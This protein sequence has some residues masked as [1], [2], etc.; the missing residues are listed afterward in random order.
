M[1]VLLDSNVLIA[2]FDS[3]HV[4]HEPSTQL[5]ECCKDGDLLIAAHSLSE[6]YN[7]LTGG[8]IGPPFAPET[9]SFILNA[10]ARRVTVGSL[11]ADLTMDAIRTFARQNG[12]GPKLYDYLIG[13]IAIVHGA[14]CIVTWN[15]RDMAPLFPTLTVVTPADFIG[16]A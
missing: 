12:R 10:F 1:K 4:H 2:Y 13:Q 5:I 8:R 9:I 3:N 11:T 14:N 6:V 7:K 15:V 16:V